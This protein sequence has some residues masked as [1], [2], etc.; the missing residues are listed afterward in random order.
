MSD[1]VLRR[2]PEA[3]T[4][5]A[6][7]DGTLAPGEVSV[8]AEHLR[9]FGDCRTVV[10]ETA[11]FKD[12][13]NAGRTSARGWWMYAAAAI[14][15]AIVAV[16]FLRTRSPIDR[17][18]ASAP[19][20]HRLVEA[21]LSGFPWARLQAPT[22]GEA[23]PDPADLKF[24]GAAGGVLE[25]TD[26]HAKGVAYLVTGHRNDSITALERAASDSKDARVWSDLA[27]ARYVSAVEDD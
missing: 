26:N 17:L 9:G 23:K 16:P 4:M 21:R 12:E 13:E 27:A 25:S 11:R 20:E 2:H 18:I 10:S 1:G 24:T 7:V 19:H 3:P 8:I 5:A 22:R 6:F 14:V 15:L